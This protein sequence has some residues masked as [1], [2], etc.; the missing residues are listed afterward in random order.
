MGLKINVAIQRKI[1]LAEGH[2]HD[3]CCVTSKC[4]NQVTSITLLMTH[5]SCKCLQNLQVSRHWQDRL[6]ITHV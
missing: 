1:F 3:W 4:V 2:D 6:F 5:L